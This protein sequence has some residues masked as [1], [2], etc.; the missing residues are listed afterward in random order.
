MMKWARRHVPLVA[1][2]SAA[3]LLSTIVLAFSLL[4]IWHE[5]KQGQ[6]KQE[7][8]DEHQQLAAE[9]T[10]VAQEQKKTGARERD[11]ALRQFQYVNRI[12]LAD[13]AWKRADFETARRWLAEC[14]PKWKE[15]DLRGFEWHWLDKQTCGT[16]P[17]WNRHEGH[18]YFVRFSPDGKLLATTGQDGVRIWSWP[19][20]KLRGCIT[21]HQNEVNGVAFSPDARILATASDD[22][23][24]RLWDIETLDQLRVIPLSAEVVAVVF[25]A[26][27]STLFSAERVVG[28]D[29]PLRS[30]QSY[31]RAWDT[32]TGQ[33]VVSV[34]AHREWIQSLAIIPD[35]KW[36]M[37][38]AGDRTAKIWDTESLEC[39][40]ELPHPEGLFCVAFAHSHPWIGNCGWE[41]NVPALECNERRIH[42]APARTHKTG[43]I[44]RVF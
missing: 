22:N 17:I 5:R 37:S 12:N 38:A 20:G 42:R 15:P 28:T 6:L 14:V 34:L 41:R 26:N 27:G 44:H 43:R 2:A 25:S 9:Q 8:A 31:I 36:L 23:T 40:R 21:G 35:G 1:S 32:A 13:D 7:L 30:H 4:V 29:T 10:K 3:V 39:L 18:C 33:Q 24:V 16:V 19:E 11:L